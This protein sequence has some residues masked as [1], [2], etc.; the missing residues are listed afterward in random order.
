M[1]LRACFSS[2]RL[3]PKYLSHS[4]QKYLDPWTLS[5]SL[6]SIDCVKGFLQSLQA[7]GVSPV[8]ILL[9]FVREAELVND[10]SQILQ[11]HGFSPLCILWWDLRVKASVKHTSKKRPNWRW[12]TFEHRKIG[13]KSAY[14]G[15]QNFATTAHQS[16]KCNEFGDKIAIFWHNIWYLCVIL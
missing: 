11:M 5:W 2:A 14:I 4:L 9:W 12:S 3:R 6:R 15:I 7:K 8:C 13:G 16:W 10:F 1:W